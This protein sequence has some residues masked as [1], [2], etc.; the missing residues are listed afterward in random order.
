MSRLLHGLNPP[1]REAVLATRGPVLVLAGAGTGKTKVITH[2]MARLIEEGVPPSQILA[3]TFTNK[4]AREMKERARRLLEGVQPPEE[5]RKLFAGTFHSFCAIALRRHIDKLG[6]KSTF[7]ILDEGDQ[8]AVLKKILGPSAVKGGDADPQRVKFLLGLAKNRGIRP[9]QVHT[10]ALLARVYRRYQEELKALNAVDFDDLLLLMA[11][12]LEK[13]PEVREELRRRHRFLLVDEY[14]DTN[15]LQFSIVRSL[16]SDTNDV[17]VV[18]DDDQSIYSWRGAEDAHILGF[19]RQFPGA[20]IIK[21][22]QNYRCTPRILQAA[23]AVIACNARRRGKTLWADGPPGD[24]IRLITASDEQD[25]ATWVVGDILRAREEHRLRWEDIAILYRANHLSR[26]F[27]TELRR[28]RVPYRVVGGQA[29]YERREIKDLLAYLQV[30]ADPGTD[31][32]LLRTVN[33]P[34]RGVGAAAVES[35]IKLSREQ[36]GS[37]WDVLQGDLPAIA[38]RAYPGLTSYR[39]L[40]RDF[41]GRFAVSTDWAATFNE[42]LVE[43]G[44]QDDLKRS[45]KDHEEY[46]SRAENVQGLAASITAYREKEPLG[47]LHSF[48][49]AILLNDRE[50]EE[51]DDDGY[52][53]TLMTLHGAKGLEFTRVYLAGV[54]EGILPHDKVKLEGNVEEERRLFYVGITR[55][56]KWLTLTRCE[57]RKRYG[58]MEPRHPSSFLAELPPDAVESMTAA[59]TRTVVE[60]SDAVSQLAALRAKLAAKAS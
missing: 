24:P 1:Q 16:V 31:S 18:G 25:E 15:G 29:F 59:S 20:R 19:E 53:V 7:T 23:N 38:P 33:T 42:L 47:T 49:D 37:L 51:E 57:A 55:A 36:G 14:Q 58:Q 56:K 44:Y 39:D 41:Q 27:E 11:D 6:Y 5:I 54:E 45:C 40:I 28:L 32:S 13:H 10:D 30:I 21:L 3:L 8:V 50:D 52:G 34:A 17:C 48:V 35:L 9:D 22:E 46:Q 2:R 60:K 4:A 43:S 12:L 26:V